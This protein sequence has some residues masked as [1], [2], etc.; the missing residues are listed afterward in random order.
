MPSRLYRYVQRLSQKA[1]HASHI[2][3]RFIDR[4]Y[5]IEFGRISQSPEAS[6]RFY[7][8]KKSPTASRAGG[9]WPPRPVLISLI[10]SYENGAAYGA[11][12]R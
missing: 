4:R 11:L 5:L 10:V 8:H 9:F 7:L 3:L 1:D 12:Y 6:F 2:I